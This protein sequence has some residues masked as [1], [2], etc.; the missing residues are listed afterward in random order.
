MLLLAFFCSHVGFL[1]FISVFYSSYFVLRLI[2]KKCKFQLNYDLCCMYVCVKKNAFAH[3]HTYMRVMRFL[4]PVLA[5][6]FCIRKYINFFLLND[7]FVLVMSCHV[8]LFSLFLMFCY[9][10]DDDDVVLLVLAFWFCC[11]G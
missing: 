5:T 4:L 8:N 3:T 1:D 11:W 7:Y 10:G 6:G 9:D 2:L